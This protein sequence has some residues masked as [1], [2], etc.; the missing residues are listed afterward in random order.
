MQDVREVELLR[1][2]LGHF[3]QAAKKKKMCWAILMRKS[4]GGT[5]VGMGI[6]CLDIPMEMLYGERSW[7]ESHQVI[8]GI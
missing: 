4:V 3:V 5:E 8:D 1:M 6:L 7:L 2:I